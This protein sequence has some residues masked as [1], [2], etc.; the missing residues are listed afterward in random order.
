MLLSIWGSWRAAASFLML[1]ARRPRSALA[2]LGCIDDPPGVR[3]TAWG[4]S[5]FWG[6]LVCSALAGELVAA[7]AGELVGATLFC[8][9]EAPWTGEDAPDDMVLLLDLLL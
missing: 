6:V 9:G 5:G 3:G 8:A 7:A 2:G 1:E 4:V